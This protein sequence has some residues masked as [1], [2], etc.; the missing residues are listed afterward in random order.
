MVT[1]KAT[2]V[3]LALWRELVLQ[4][5]S[6]S[7]VLPASSQQDFAN[8]QQEPTALTTPSAT[9][10]VGNSTILMVILIMVSAQTLLF[11]PLPTAAP[12]R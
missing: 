2:Q 1:A 3:V 11:H 4:T 10:G 8:F 6:A 9:I 7:K 12:L 5:F